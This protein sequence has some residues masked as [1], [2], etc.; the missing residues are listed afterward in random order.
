[1]IS[2]EI[3]EESMLKSK[4][5]ISAN[6]VGICIRNSLGNQTENRV[7]NVMNQ[8]DKYA[9]RYKEGL[10]NVI[11]NKVWDFR[12]KYVIYSKEKCV[13]IVEKLDILCIFIL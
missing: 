11:R 7:E 5:I 2:E 6:N 8:F 9:D 12:C 3:L 13:G 4:Y 1:M 10:G